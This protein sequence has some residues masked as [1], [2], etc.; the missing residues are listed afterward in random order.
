MKNDIYSDDLDLFTNFSET[1]A[2]SAREIIDR[3]ALTNYA[4]GKQV[5]S[6]DFIRI[7][8]FKNENLLQVDFVNDRVEAIW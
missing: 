7:N 2:Y 4:V 1:F 8:V 5:D 3:I 6:K